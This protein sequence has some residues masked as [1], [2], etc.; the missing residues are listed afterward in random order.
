MRGGDLA[1]GLLLAS[2]VLGDPN[3]QRTIVL[4]GKHGDTG[5]IGWVVNGRPLPAVGELLIASGLVPE[6]IT[7]PASVAFRAAARVGGP[8]APA[9]GWL[10]YRRIEGR[11]LAGEIE[12]G[13]E[14]AVTGDATALGAVILGQEPQAFRFLIGCAGWAPGQLEAELAAG[15]WL[16][17]DVDLALVL[18][19]DPDAQ[20]DKAYEKTIGATPVAFTSTRGG[21]A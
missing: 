7:L 17:A 4:L 20:W 9:S 16:P 2:P 15:A 13:P 12:I 8:V 3:F 5:A 18:D 14:L 1:P 6:G 21:S 11:S 19:V 10:L